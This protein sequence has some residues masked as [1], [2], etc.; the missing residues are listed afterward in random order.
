MIGAKEKFGAR[1]RAVKVKFDSFSCEDCGENEQKKG[2]LYA[3][4]GKNCDCA[5]GTLRCGLGGKLFTNCSGGWNYPVETFTP[6]RIFLKPHKEK[7]SEISTFRLGITS[8]VYRLYEYEKDLNAY[9]QYL[10][11]ALDIKPVVA[12]DDKEESAVCVYCGAGV[13]WYQGGNGGKLFSISTSAGINFA[14]RNFFAVRPYRVY[15]S[16]LM[17]PIT[18][19][20][21][22]NDSG[23]LD[24][25]EKGGLVVEFAEL[26]DTLYAFRQFGVA[27]LN[28]RGKASEFSVET[29]PYG[30]GEIFV[31]SVATC[32]DKIF[33][34]ARDGLWTFNGKSFE[35]ASVGKRILPNWS[36]PNFRAAYACG[37]YILQYTDEKQENCSFVVS[38]DGKSGYF[39]YYKNALSGSMG[40][41][42]CYRNN[43][44]EYVA[45]DGTLPSGEK[46]SFTGATN[47]GYSGRKT[48]K[49]VTLRGKGKAQFSVT[50]EGGNRTFAL[51]F[52]DGEQT[53]RVDL[54]GRTFYPSFELSAGAEVQAFS[55]DIVM[56]EK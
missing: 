47:F 14:G 41:A 17:K 55:A 6:F 29:L 46:Y 4:D 31:G 18:F 42:L 19:E 15:F 43:A 13:W 24:L 34:M 25:P 48:L 54:K 32:G 16:A 26:G 56:L 21:S 2:V 44:I 10:S 49:S 53:V 37:K 45:E 50:S 51:D 12:T 33:F 27:R 5:D 30:G 8:T 28:A 22:A 20:E 39:G 40:Y 23:W 35:K 36:K 38:L 11:F 9:K 3:V 7:N 1:G 52:S